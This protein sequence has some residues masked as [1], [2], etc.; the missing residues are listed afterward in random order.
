MTKCYYCEGDFAPTNPN[1]DVCTSCLDDFSA[2]AES[3]M[4]AEFAMS[5]VCGGGAPEDASAAY[6]QLVEE[7]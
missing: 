1:D 7:Q 3:E 5:Y 6:H 4:R 2:Q